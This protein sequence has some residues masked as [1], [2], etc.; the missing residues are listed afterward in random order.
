MTTLLAIGCA[1]SGE[2]GMEEETAYANEA[3]AKRPVKA[4]V[5]M[6]GRLATTLSSRYTTQYARNAYYEQFTLNRGQ[7]LTAQTS[8]GSPSTDTVLVIY[9]R[10]DGQ[11]DWLGNQYTDQHNIWTHALNDDIGVGIFYSSVSWTNPTV[12]G[13]DNRKVFLQCFSYSYDTSWNTVDS[14]TITITSPGGTVSKTINCGTAIHPYGTNGGA[15][16]TRYVSGGSNDPALF[17][18]QEPT[19]STPDP[20]NTFYND[21]CGDNAYKNPSNS[22]DACVTGV[23]AGFDWVGVWSRTNDTIVEVYGP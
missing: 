4:P 17:V 16:Y 2:P 19:P 7:S 9:E 3:L 10:T 8:N 23:P 11:S 5:N 6:T 13:W 20:S 18:F 1:D 14:A 22:L 12:G 21:D 15:F